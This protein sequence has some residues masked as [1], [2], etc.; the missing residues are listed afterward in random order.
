M[1]SAQLYN[2]W[3]DEDGKPAPPPPLPV[4][5]KEPPLYTSN[6]GKVH[7]KVFA[8]PLLTSDILRFMNKFL[9]KDRSNNVDKHYVFTERFWEFTPDGVDR[10]AY[11]VV[12]LKEGRLWYPLGLVIGSNL[13]EEDMQ[14]ARDEALVKQVQE[15]LEV[16]TQ[17]AW[18]HYRNPD[19]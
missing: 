15:I 16:K 7:P 2:D 12:P 1:S 18:Y 8:I 13:N 3:H 19:H 9:P 11:I 6:P 4:C 5:L 14:Q 10:L 17:P